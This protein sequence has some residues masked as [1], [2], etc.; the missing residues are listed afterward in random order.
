MPLQTAF[1]N[2]IFLLSF[3]PFL[4]VVPDIEAE[5]QPI[6]GLLAG[7]FILLYRFKLDQQAFACFVILALI[8]IYTLVSTLLEYELTTTVFQ[9]IAYS[10]PILIFLA[11]KDS[12]PLLSKRLYLA[13]LFLN[14]AVGLLQYFG[15]Y[16]PI[17]SFFRLDLLFPRS[18]GT[19]ELGGGRGVSLFTPEPSYSAMIIM[20]FWASAIFFYVRR[21]TSRIEFPLLGAV[22]VTMVLLN[23]SGTG[24]V[25]CALFAVGYLSG[26]SWL[27]RYKLRYLASILVG[28]VLFIFSWTLLSSSIL[29]DAQEINIRFVTLMR[30][31]M[32]REFWGKN[33]DEMM[34][35]IAGKRYLTVYVGYYSLFTSMG[36]GY[37]I[38]SYATKFFEV[39][40]LGGVDFS[41]YAVFG[42]LERFASQLKPD[43]FAAAFAM[44]TGLL[45]LAAVTYLA[46][47]C[48]FYR[49]RSG[50]VLTAQM[51]LRLGMFFVAFYTVFFHTA[52][53]LPV[54]WVFLAI[55]R[56]GFLPVNKG[57]VLPF[58][59]VVAMDPNI[60]R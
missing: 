23:R 43:S 7:L 14:L 19:L 45:G 31:V 53:S 20:Q 55:I 59:P 48:Y 24:I 41:T 34:A 4:R 52:T 18:A 15:A 37:G 25:L 54:P 47:G 29:S 21:Q 11:L 38:G 40:V 1:V 12:L 33:L 10:M 60:R 17:V 51:P 50:V 58:A 30:K 6:A 27:A 46:V 2:L 42:E 39:S 28:A 9:G 44:D 3:F 22:I 36:L 13:V 35:E 56:G 26:L 16:E 49:N 8:V 57:E 32:D 5:V